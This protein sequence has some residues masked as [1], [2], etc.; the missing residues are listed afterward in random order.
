MTPEHV[1]QVVKRARAARLVAVYEHATG[2][3]HFTAEKPPD[4]N[5]P[6]YF[7]ADTFIECL[8]FMQGWAS[9]EFDA[10]LRNLATA[11]HNGRVAK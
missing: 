2:Q 3:V 5:A 7:S 9:R 8:A 11:I 4:P 6:P 1:A 10:T